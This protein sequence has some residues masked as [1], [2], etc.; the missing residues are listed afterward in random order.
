MHSQLRGY[1]TLK[2]NN[3]GLVLLLFFTIVAGGSA[4]ELE[5]FDLNDFIDPRLLEPISPDDGPLHYLSVRFD[6]GFINDYQSRFAF[7]NSAGP[8]GQAALNLYRG[9]PLGDDG[10]SRGAWQFSADAITFDFHK[11]ID[12][13]T[14]RF[15]EKNRL[16]LR[17][18]RYFRS[19]YPQVIESSDGKGETEVEVFNRVS[20]NLE[21]SRSNSGQVTKAL[22]LHWDWQTKLLPGVLNGFHYMLVPA[23]E[24]DGGYDRHYFSF[25]DRGE[26]HRYQNGMRLMAGLGVGGERTFGHTK[27]RSV[28]LETGV[29]FP[30]RILRTDFR[31][32][33]APAWQPQNRNHLSGW[34]QEFSVVLSTRLSSRL[35]SQTG[36]EL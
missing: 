14:N 5:V 16:N 7:T 1:N 17:V 32:V 3:P 29:W 27:F 33:W 28:R 34:N 18:G 6:L 21:I 4:Q 26:I 22:G 2:K 15:N 36:H 11:F 31:F 20:A 13:K 30:I 12:E 35:Y 25:T 8:F 10:K 24:G 19:S 23:G 9:L